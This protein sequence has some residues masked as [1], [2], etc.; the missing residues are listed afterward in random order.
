MTVTKIMKSNTPEKETNTM[1]FAEP[2]DFKKNQIPTV[3]S[4]VNWFQSSKTSKTQQK[5]NSVE[6]FANICSFLPP[7]D[8]CSLRLTC[9]FFEE[10]L[11]SPIDTLTQ[12]IWGNS[13]KQF[14]NF[15]QISPP[16]GVSEQAYQ[17][18]VFGVIK[19]QLCH[20]TKDE[21]LIYWV[22]KIRCCT[23]CLNRNI[24][25]QQK[26]VKD[27]DIP[28]E[29]I[30]ILVPIT[31]RDLFGDGVQY[32]W[33]P[34]VTKSL[35]KYIS[36]EPKIKERWLKKKSDQAKK[37]MAVNLERE[38]WD[39]CRA[40]SNKFL[41]S[42]KI[43]KNIDEENGLAIANLQRFSTLATFKDSF[44]LKSPTIAEAEDDS[45][46]MEV[47]ISLSN[48]QI[49]ERSHE[50]SLIGKKWK[51]ENHEIVICTSMSPSKKRDRFFSDIDKIIEK[52]NLGS[53]REHEY[54]LIRTQRTG[55]ALRPTKKKKYSM[56]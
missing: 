4:L 21:A 30:S 54:G 22:P 11:G 18:L 19:C 39:Y 38:Y 20:D 36:L 42:G 43:K 48:K 13:R 31:Q 1:F 45:A 33:L 50:S 15:L 24:I 52:I 37:N 16:I 28:Q 56:N 27:W 6:I 29:F 49:A 25:S 14:S 51:K 47:D 17:N 12:Q 46:Q 44:E 32:Y 8:L 5:V 2:S 7:S 3:T 9:K 55:Y 41:N 34:S 40:I 23:S 10:L 26:L 35:N 53:E